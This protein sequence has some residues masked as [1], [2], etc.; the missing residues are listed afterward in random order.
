MAVTP[1]RV[2]EVTRLRQGLYRFFAAALLYPEPGR[3]AQLTTVSRALTGLEIFAFYGPWRQLTRALQKLGDRDVAALV[4]TYVRLFVTGSDGARCPPQASCY[5]VPPGQPPGLFLAHLEQEYA[6]FGLTLS[7]IM[8]HT[9]DHV[10]VQLEVMA[11][12]CDREARAWEHRAVAEASR[13]LEAQHAFLTQHLGRWFSLFA[14]GVRTADATGL[15]GLIAAAADAFIHH[16]Q[17]YLQVV[18]T[19]WH[20]NPRESNV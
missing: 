11:F 6:R 18:R 10:A 14:A 20:Q 15:Y 13:I 19:A 4:E 12:L 9:P 7:R 1:L 16:D 3:L 5:L 17:D 2:D 8:P